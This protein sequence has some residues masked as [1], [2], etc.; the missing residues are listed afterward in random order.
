MKTKREYA[1]HLINKG[2]WIFPLPKGQTTP[3]LPF[4]EV[5]SSDIKQINKWWRTSK[6]PRN[7]GVHTGG[8]L[9]VF[10]VDV[11]HSGDKSLDQLVKDNE[12]LPETFTV[13]TPSG[14]THYY[15]TSSEDIRNS[16]GKL[17]EGLDIRGHNGYVVAPGSHRDAR[18]TKK[19]GTYDI[20]DDKDF[21][22]MPEWLEKL[23]LEDSA[24]KT[25]NL[26]DF[27]AI[28][29]NDDPLEDVPA[30]QRNNVLF[31]EASGLRGKGWKQGAIEA[32]IIARNATFSDPLPLNEI[33]LIVS[34]AS[35][36]EP[37]TPSF[38]D[39]HIIE[40]KESL[41][42]DDHRKRA[43]EAIKS[44]TFLIKETINFK[45][46]CDL[47]IAHLI[48]SSSFWQPKEARLHT[49][50]Q[51]SLKVLFS[52]RDAIKMLVEL[53]GNPIVNFDALCSATCD[54][55][56]SLTVVQ[57]RE[58]RHVLITKL[59]DVIKINNQRLALKLNVDMFTKRTYFEFDPGHAIEN[60]K[61]FKLK[62]TCQP[63]Y[64]EAAVIDYKEHFPQ[65][66]NV[67][68]LIIAARF[69]GSRKKAYL[70][71][72][73]P[74]DWGKDF[75]RVALG[76]I[77]VE[78]SV[79][80][81]E[82]AL[83]G[84]PVGKSPNDFHRTM[85]MVTNEF[86]SVKS[87]LKQLEDSIVLSAKYQLETKIPLYTKLF[88]SAEGVDSLI[89]EYGIESQ[90]A[91]RFSLIDCQ[92]DLTELISFKRLGSR[93]LDVIKTYCTDFM[94]REIA[95]YRA[96]GFYDSRE[97]GDKAVVSFHTRYGIK[98]VNATIEDSL[99]E[100][101]QLIKEEILSDHTLNLIREDKYRHL[102]CA[103]T[104][105]SNI[106]FSNK[107]VGRS[108]AYTLKY[109]IDELCK[110]I[111]VDGK[112]IASHRIGENVK[113]TLKLMSDRPKLEVVKE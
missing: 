82:K 40:A 65:L 87:E 88:L 81:V 11:H 85:V 99:E 106:L 21:A 47:D 75:F 10:D 73:A 109:K 62:P 102:Q 66:D 61:H 34:Q 83:E 90:F 104:I 68:K 105:I 25:I 79:K 91:N 103:K 13:S 20:V 77:A 12:I 94:N 100:L 92:G 46:E 45:L 110:L 96:M 8:G 24:P 3:D 89:G 14:G 26:K 74:S 37:N 84:A 101:A 5:S 35:K 17:G 9:I 38:Y 86:K 27:G 97:A 93:F 28:K 29:D 57:K 31:K 39:S 48:I 80:E 72:K 113:K 63:L 18:K 69:A 16:A 43:K 15:F 41:N 78:M 98:K 23:C 54:E 58:A 30:G 2:L 33:D 19:G 71:L 53:F 108:E 52:E 60:H 49:I 111:S 51:Q 1:T 76:T 70:W 50:N 32:A 22:P 56:L 6:S 36:Y 44:A 59:F 67:L 7:I 4:S 42:D 107:I 112:G 95:R 64:D 55:D